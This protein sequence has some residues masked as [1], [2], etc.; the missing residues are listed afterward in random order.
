MKSLKEEIK[1]LLINSFGDLIPKN[2][3]NLI[4]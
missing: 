1:D 4:L 3:I 2:K